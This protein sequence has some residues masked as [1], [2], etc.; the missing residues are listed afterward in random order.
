MIKVGLS[1]NNFSGKNTVS[2]IFKQLSIPVFDADVVL[3]FIINYDIETI[4]T[5]KDRLGESVFINGQVSKYLIKD[6]LSMDIILDCANYKLFRA[7]QRF[8]EK[9]P[10]SVYTIFKS[11]FLFES[12]WYKK[13]DY[14]VSVFCPKINRMERIHE[15]TGKKVSQIAFDLRSEMDDLDKNR[16]S[17]FVIHNYGNK[18]VLDYVNQVDTIIIDEFLKKERKFTPDGKGII[19]S[20]HY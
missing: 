12:D 16:L 19:I 10:N 8:E 20:E 4:K 11:S 1:G 2:K 17:N 13:L 9:H 18:D 15:L 6:R 7:Y 3:K 14:N 5:I